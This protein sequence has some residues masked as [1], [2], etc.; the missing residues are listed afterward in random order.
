MLSDS[1]GRIETKS[2][3]AA[4]AGSAVRV[5]CRKKGVLAIA[6]ARVHRRARGPLLQTSPGSLRGLRRC[7]DRLLTRIRNHGL[8]GVW[9]IGDSEASK[10]RRRNSHQHEIRIS[11]RPVQRLLFRLKKPVDHDCIFLDCG[12]ARPARRLA[13][14]HRR[15]GVDRNQGS[16]R[17]SHSAAVGNAVRIDRAMAHL[18]PG[19]RRTD[20]APR[21]AIGA[22]ATAGPINSDTGKKRLLAG[23]PR[24]R[25]QEHQNKGYQE[26]LQHAL[27]TARIGLARG[28]GRRPRRKGAIF[29][30]QK[31]GELASNKAV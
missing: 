16:V 24:G 15:T 25:H 12:P 27:I 6:S 20:M 23:K 19:T 10:I 8:P 7:C 28:G 31:V 3:N 22:A 4:R 11:S 14:N 1:R 2:S 17:E 26:S 29:D 5:D 18:E 21:P 13:A 9:G 30:S